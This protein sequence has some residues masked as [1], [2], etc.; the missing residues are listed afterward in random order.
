MN[1]NAFLRTLTL[2]LILAVLAGSALSAF[3]FQTG[4]AAGPITVTSTL[5]QLGNDGMCT[6]REA[7]IA[8]NSGKPSGSKANECLPVSGSNVIQLQPITYNLTRTDNG[9]EDSASTGDLDIRSNIII[10]VNGVGQA[11]IQA[12]NFHDRVFQVISGTV[13]ISNVLIQGGNLPSGN[14]GAIGNWGTLTLNNSYLTGNTTPAQGGGL[15]NAAGAS[16][17][18][19]GST[20]AG[21]TATGDGGGLSNDGTATLTNTTV[22]GNTSNGSG[23]GIV[24]RG[25]ITLNAVTVTANQTKS[26]SGNGGGV[27]AAAGTFNIKGTLIAG[28]SSVAATP[29]PDCAVTS[30]TTLNSN[31]YNLIQN[32]AG[33]TFSGNTT[34]NIVNPTNVFLDSQLKN[35]GG[36]TPT[37]ALLAGSPAIDRH[38]DH[39]LPNQRS[40]S[41][42]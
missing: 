1:K 40:T 29:Y 12:Q 25:T 38:P 27:K 28:N 4:K 20:L 41:V 3:S 36:P 37:I 34:G 14:G 21:N 26:T 5:D 9:N 32:P 35:N 11:T 33:C 42:A 31:G 6:L 18:V 23:G 19:T 17:T 8:A 24:N 39:S 22:S 15:Y 16:L 30:T 7:I 10:Q 13:S 2:G